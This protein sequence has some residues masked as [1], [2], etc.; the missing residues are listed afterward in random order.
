MANVV[1][2][3]LGVNRV[4][5][6]AAAEGALPAAL[7]RLHPRFQTPHVA[8]VVT[9]LVSTALL[10][11]NAM[12]SARADNVFW[13]VFKLSGVC[14]LVSYLLL[15]PA[16]LILR[17]RRPHH[18]RPIRDAGR[19]G[20]GVAR[21]RASA[22]CSW[23]ASCLLFFRPSPTAADPASAV[24]ESWVLLAETLATAVVG[25]AVDA[26]R[27]EPSADGARSA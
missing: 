19:A 5:A 3:S 7:G 9:G 11:G 26:A 2:W 4:A 18:P 24:R 21:G 25:L 13:M 8:F 1:T 16:F 15:F 20:G 12:L 17:H 27:G 6:A 14:L 23:P 10:L 22:G